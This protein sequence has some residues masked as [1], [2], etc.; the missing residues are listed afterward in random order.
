MYKILL[1]LFFLAAFIASFKMDEMD[2]SNAEH[3]Y[4]FEK[5]S[6]ISPFNY[7]NSMGLIYVGEP[8]PDVSLYVCKGNV[9]EDFVRFQNPRVII[10]KSIKVHR[11]P[12]KRI[13]ALAENSAFRQLNDPVNGW[14]IPLLSTIPMKGRAPFHLNAYELASRGFNGANA[15]ITLIDSCFYSSYDCQ[16]LKVAENDVNGGNVINVPLDGSDCIHGTEMWSILTGR[17]LCTT[18]IVPAVNINAKEINIENNMMKDLAFARALYGEQSSIIVYSFNSMGVDLYGNGI[19]LPYYSKEDSS[20]II[21]RAINSGSQRGATYFTSAGNYGSLDN[22]TS[23]TACFD[24][25]IA[26]MMNLFP[27]AA[28]CPSGSCWYTNTG[29][30]AFSA[31]GGDENSC[32]SATDG[33]KCTCV[34]GTSF[35]APYAASLAAVLQQICQNTL[36]GMDIYDIMVRSSTTENVDSKVGFYFLKNG[37]GYSYSNRYGHGLLNFNAAISYVQNNKCPHVPRIISCVSEK[38]FINA[39]AQDIRIVNIPSPSNCAITTVNFV[40]VHATFSYPTSRLFDWWISSPHKAI[41]CVLL[42][43]QHPYNQPSLDIETGCRAFYG[44]SYLSN[45]S[46]AIHYNN[47]YTKPS[48]TTFMLEIFGYESP[49]KLF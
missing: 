11:K 23:A 6:G 46:W 47:Q 15:T 34:A 35:A 18:G 16:N 37:G 10:P 25:M 45:G 33:S 19:Y 38:L 29:C 2:L 26:G 8:L 30:I 20:V 21:K 22:R 41:P 14:P 5:E 27:I 40:K 24:G 1:L 36:N 9:T 28:N 3:V 49:L 44:E 42:G 17:Q 32:I 13:H 12:L 43:K 4:Y 31:P 39:T 7:C 48:T